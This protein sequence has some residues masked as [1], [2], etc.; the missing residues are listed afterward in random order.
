MINWIIS[1]VCLIIAILLFL[2]YNNGYGAIGSTKKRITYAFSILFFIAFLFFLNKAYYFN[3][4]QQYKQI[5][6]DLS[7][8]YLLL[9]KEI[10]QTNNFSSNL[11]IH[12][13]Q[14]KVRTLIQ[15]LNSDT[16]KEYDTYFNIFI[17]ILSAFIGWVIVFTFRNKILG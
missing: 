2:N 6:K 12:E 17:N 3:D 16:H 8:E 1:G 4:N 5:T 7:S 11:N 13:K 10:C 15:Q 14:F 9:E